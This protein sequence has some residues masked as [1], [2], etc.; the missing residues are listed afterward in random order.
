MEFRYELRVPKDRVAVVV[1]AKG[2][3]KRRIE[4]ETESKIE[5]D[6]KEGDVFISGNDG[7]K[8]NV[9]KEIVL[10]IGR[11]FNPETAMLLLRSD[12]MFE[13][14]SLNDYSK[15]K[16][17]H[18]RL[19]GRVI[20]KEGRSRTYIEQTCECFV[21]V[22]GKTV[23][24]IGEVERCAIATQAIKMLLQGSPH[25]AVF[26]WLDKKG[27]TVKINELSG[28]DISSSVKDDF[29]KYVE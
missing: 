7:I 26:K 13:M 23:A 24:I 16:N 19:K 9:A 20:G 4:T 1:G 29:Q 2:T 21:S 18:L 22:Y 12:Y 6:S 25:A 5:I 15:H 27:K 14:L 17:H 8:L 10:A 28:R 3:V 11:G